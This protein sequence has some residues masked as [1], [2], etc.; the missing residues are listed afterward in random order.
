ML[1]DVSVNRIRD[2][3]LGHR[4]SLAMSRQLVLFTI[5]FVAAPRAFAQEAGHGTLQSTSSIGSAPQRRNPAFDNDEH[6]PNPWHDRQQKCEDAASESTERPFGGEQSRSAEW[7]H[8]IS[9]LQD[10][11]NV[12]ELHR[13]IMNPLVAYDWC[14]YYIGDEVC[15]VFSA[16]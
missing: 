14:N 9:M 16:V 6:P 7:K 11:G 13:L 12:L 5:I 3:E 8:G 4:D 1:S 10:E 15:N 2:G